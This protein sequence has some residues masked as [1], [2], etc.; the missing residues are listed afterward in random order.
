VAVGH[1]GTGML[2]IFRRAA[3]ALAAL[4]LVLGS[5][6]SALPQAGS[7]G[8]SSAQPSAVPAA[9]KAE[10]IVVITIDREIDAIMAKSVARRIK[11]AEESGADAIVIELN[12]PGGHLG[13]VREICTA[14]K[15]SKIPNSV[16]WVRPTAYSGGAVIALACREIVV[17]QHAAMGDAA[18][19]R[20]NF[21]ML[22]EMQET[23]RQKMLAPLL[24]EVVNSARLRGYDERLVQAFVSRGVDLYRI[25][26]TR[27]GEQLFVGKDEY[28]RIFG[29]DPPAHPYAVP[30]ASGGVPYGQGPGEG[31]GDGQAG[32]RVLAGG[33]GGDPNDY[34]PAIPNLPEQ[35]VSEVSAGM[36][37]PSRRP[38][39]T[40]A[41]A[42]QWVWTENV[43]DGNGILTLGT[44]QMLRYHLAVDTVQDDEA[45]K[46]FFG[47]S[48]MVRLDES[49]SERLVVILTNWMVRAVLIVIFLVSLFIEMT[50]PGLILPG[51]V[52]AIALMVLIAAPFLNNMA[53]WWEISAILIGI[54]LLAAEIFVLPGFGFF[55]VLGIVLLFGGLI[56]TFATDSD[57]LFPDTAKGRQDLMYGVAAMLLSTVVSGI[58]IYMI[59]KH[60][61]SLPIVG[62]LVLKDTPADDDADAD[63][64]MLGAMEQ[65]PVELA[66]GAIGLAL[67]PLR[68]A[69]RVQIGEQIYDVVAEGGFVTA[70]EPVRVISVGPFRTVVERAPN[71]PGAGPGAAGA[72]QGGKA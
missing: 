38:V 14:I 37:R 35:V 30:S 64:E 11:M 15:T 25:E 54:L 4:L 53:S 5:T 10:R 57:G 17:T 3:G 63:A 2:A 20:V 36:D 31:G 43:A 48:Q 44:D 58:T 19:I 9:R 69:G 71:G 29:E 16:A 62:R 49:W 21:G 67:T 50:H 70:G 13:A 18:I 33:S 24:I 66:P 39:L 34:K 41:D 6:V 40:R 46:N 55:G 23:E 47:A 1:G 52:A 7:G 61:G 28:R 56:G 32:G 65:G 42:D 12:T 72:G 45:L 51:S 60:L 68:P 22:Q 59:G 26:N 8:G 27:T